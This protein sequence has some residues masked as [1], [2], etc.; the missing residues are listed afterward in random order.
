MV[1]PFGGAVLWEDEF[2][3]D[4]VTSENICVSGLSEVARGWIGCQQSRMLEDKLGFLSWFACFLGPH[5]T[6]P[7]LTCAPAM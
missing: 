4:I 7:T 5:V 6:P 2:T 3:G 1:E